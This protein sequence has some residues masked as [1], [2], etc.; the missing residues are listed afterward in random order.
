LVAYWFLVPFHYDDAFFGP[1]YRAIAQDERAATQWV[2]E[3]GGDGGSQGFEGS[4]QRGL[5]GIGLV[6]FP[7]IAPES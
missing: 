5:V 1:D 6:G 4:G 7:R 3:A 2:L